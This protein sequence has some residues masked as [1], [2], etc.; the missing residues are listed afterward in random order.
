MLAP[1]GGTNLD[2]YKQ[3]NSTVSSG[4]SLCRKHEEVCTFLFFRLLSFCHFPF[5][6]VHLAR[7]AFRSRRPPGGQSLT[8]EGDTV[9]DREG[10]TTL[11]T[12]DGRELVGTS[13]G[14]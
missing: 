12:S 3:L 14:S 6:F 7:L 10:I 2:S 8:L 4:D 13:L 1:A 11:G 5:V 9:G